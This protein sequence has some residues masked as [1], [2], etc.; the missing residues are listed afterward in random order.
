MPVDKNENE[1]N[2]GSLVRVVRINPRVIEVL[3]EAEAR[4]VSSM[5]NEVLMVYE[6]DECG[7]VWVEKSWDRGDGQ[8]ECHSLLLSSP[9]MEL[10][11][12]INAGA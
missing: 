4:D 1:V 8:T 12:E 10:V 5:L 6:I 7:R 2:V 11:N 3:S 9:D